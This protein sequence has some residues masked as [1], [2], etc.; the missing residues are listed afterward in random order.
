MPTSLT[1]KSTELTCRWIQALSSGPWFLKAAV[2]YV[3]VVFLRFAELIVTMLDPDQLQ[4][5]EFTPTRFCAKINDKHDTNSFWSRHWSWKM[6]L[7]TCDMNSSPAELVMK[8]DQNARIRLQFGLAD[9][10]NRGQ[11]T[12]KLTPVT[13]EIAFVE[14]RTCRHCPN[15]KP[16]MEN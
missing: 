10:K 9:L 12:S 2:R 13:S 8:F 3:G 14:F 7:Q 4:H 15:L 16:S 11:P 5:A 6:S 1:K